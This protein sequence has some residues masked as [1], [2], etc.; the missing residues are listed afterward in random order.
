MSRLGTETAFEVMVRARALEAQ[1]KDVVH[2]EVGE[3]DFDT[4]SNVIDAGVA[5]LQ[6]GWTHYGPAGGDPEL[7]EAIVSYINGAR[8]LSYTA[9]QVVVTP[10]G[11]PV[12]F[13]LILALLEAGD[14]AIYP[15]PG[16]PI[17]RSMIDFTGAKSVPIPLREENQFT[18]DVDELESL[19]TDK[20][21]LLIINSPA[22]PTGGVLSKEQLQR[23]AELAV[24]H[25]LIVMSD[26]IY[27]EL[28]YEGE[29]VSIA[30]FPGMADRTV[31]LDGFSKTYAMTGWRLGYGIF[32]KEIAPLVTKL[33]VNSV[34]C[35]SVAVQ[36]AG[37]EALTG[38]QDRVAEFREAFRGRRNLIVDGLN[39][40][41]GISCVLPK[42]A[43]YAFPN[44]KGTGL[45][46]KEF[47][48]R[49]L[50]EYG[51]AGIAG[52]SFGDAGEGYVRFSTANSEA[53]LS[54][55]LERI[56]A[57]VKAVG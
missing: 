57:L 41:E 53:N 49:L 38:P 8:G 47:A 12:M 23:I 46:S 17:Y 31:I 1:G 54:R 37:I 16:F 29:H 40:I 14:E 5:A 43:F 15:V 39:A 34:S 3:P 42:G 55:A 25:D 4:P 24:E 22:N 33:A 21:K 52:T 30:T 36:R 19:I 13:F 10:G 27:A 51:V 48:D 44:I 32:P 35:T 28:I 26:E 7:K 6:S 45:S 2:L 18:L 11:K 50:E 56:A 9:D 20:T